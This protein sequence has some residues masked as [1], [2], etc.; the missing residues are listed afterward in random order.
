MRTLHAMCARKTVDIKSS[1][2]DTD[3]DVCIQE[4]TDIIEEGDKSTSK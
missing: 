1:M 2:G 3:G 4:N